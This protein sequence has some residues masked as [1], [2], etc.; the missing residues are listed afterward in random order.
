MKRHEYI[1]AH[2]INLDKLC[3]KMRAYSEKYSS[4]NLTS[5]ACQKL[6]AEMNWLGMN[7]SQTEERIAFGLGLLLPEN[8][9]SEYNPSGFHKYSGIRF[10]LEK[11]KFES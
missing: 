1:K 8:C 6:N 3:K 4:G 9:I 5:L 7:I 10:E 11:T 2:A